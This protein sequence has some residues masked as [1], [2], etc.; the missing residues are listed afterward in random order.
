MAI[1]INNTRTITGQ[2]DTDVSNQW[3]DI[4]VNADGGDCKFTH[5]AP[6]DLSGDTL[7]DYVDGKED[8]YKRELLR[9]MYVGADTYNSPLE[10]FEKWVA[11]G[12][13]NA[14]ITGKDSEDN[15]IV[16]KAAEVIT[17]KTWINSH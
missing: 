6:S 13:T 14:E 11:A 17:K 10:D 3:I 15:D 9:N 12:C 7:Q 1:V 4:T 5:T 16:I 8:F 2:P